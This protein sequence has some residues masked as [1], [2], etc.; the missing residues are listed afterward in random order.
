MPARKSLKKCKLI[1]V[2]VGS[3]SLTDETGQ[4]DR[5]NLR[6]IAAELSELIKQGKKVILV[7]SGAIVTGREKLK[8]KGKTIPEKQAAAA[9]GQSYL[10]KEYNASFGNFGILVAQI[11]LTRD[12]IAD[13]ERYINIRNT[14]TTLL[15]YGVVPIINE[16]DTVSIDEIKVGDNDNLAALVASLIGADLVINLTNT[17]GFYI[18]DPKTNEQI[19]LDV[20][21]KITQEIEEAAGPAGHGGTGGMVSKIESAEILGDAGIPLVIAYGRSPQALEKILNGE[22]IG[23]LFLPRLSR[24]QSRKRWL[25]HGLPVKGKIFVDTGAA[26][27]IVGKGC[28]LLAVGIQDLKG[29]FKTGEAV[30]ILIGEREIARGLINCNFEELGQ[31]KG[32]KTA[33]IE[34][35]L[36]YKCDEIIHRDNLVVL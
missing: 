29:K 33:E 28:S 2:K 14:L 7:T 36:G 20:V 26:Q 18:R 5:E 15:N 4:L 30:S 8:L 17:E 13:R 11:L 10:M 25:A 34:K 16:N 19:Y 3:T 35:I 27:A 6:R 1:V 31:I 9:V 24:L 32:L 22:K 21:E 12:A 23:T